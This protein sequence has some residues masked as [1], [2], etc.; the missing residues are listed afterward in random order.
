[1][2]ILRNKRYKSIK[3]DKIYT[4][5]FFYKE[6]EKF[7]QD[8][9]FP[10]ILNSIVF[11]PENKKNGDLTIYQVLK[12]GDIVDKYLF[13]INN[14]Q[15][16]NPIINLYYSDKN[17]PLIFSIKKEDNDV[18]ISLNTTLINNFK[19]YELLNITYKNEYMRI[20]FSEYSDH[21]KMVIDSYFEG[22]Y[23]NGLEF[24][25]NGNI[26]E[27]PF[28]I[29][30]TTSFIKITFELIDDNDINWY[31]EFK[32]FLYQV[33]PEKIEFKKLSYHIKNYNYINQEINP[34]DYPELENVKNNLDIKN[35]KIY[36]SSD[37]FYEIKY[38]K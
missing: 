21:I 30:N 38:I 12:N 36:Y 23:F 8:E 37:Y 33:D 32:D 18:I 6:Y 34:I 26:I 7:L 4:N 15:S 3:S 24:K 29:L 19:F 20:E 22:N 5:S 28:L 13:F 31:L 35:L 1:M 27:N 14:L 2:R 25:L 10:N 16:Q 17:L 9:F 11:P